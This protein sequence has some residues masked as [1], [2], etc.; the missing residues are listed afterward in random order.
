MTRRE[1]AK[2]ALLAMTGEVAYRADTFAMTKKNA[3]KILLKIP[4]KE[5]KRRKF[6]VQFIRQI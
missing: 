2:R 6:K 3:F 4:L 1:F 5:F